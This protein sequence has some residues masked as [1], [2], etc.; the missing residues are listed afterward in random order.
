MA[1]W[2]LLFSLP[3]KHH[4][5]TIGNFVPNGRS[6][7]MKGSCDRFTWL[8]RP[9]NDTKQRFNPKTDPMGVYPERANW[10]SGRSRDRDATDCHHRN[11]AKGWTCRDC[12]L[13]QRAAQRRVSQLG[14]LSVRLVVGLRI[15]RDCDD[16]IFS[17]GPC[18]G[19]S[20]EESPVY[21]A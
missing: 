13:R 17:G 6:K 9:L 3:Q 15:R 16:P 4:A 10:P 19:P 5:I 14:T 1:L 7:G 18:R 20:Y 21:P 11:E 12:L 8:T 2:P